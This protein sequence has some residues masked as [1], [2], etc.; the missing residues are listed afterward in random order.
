MTTRPTPIR[1]VEADSLSLGA[2]SAVV[3]RTHRVVREQ[4]RVMREQRSRRRSLWAPVAICS[5]LLVIACYAIWSVMNLNDINADGVIDSS[6]QMFIVMV[7]LLP[8]SAAIF[9]LVWMRRSRAAG[10]GEVS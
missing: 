10:V 4:A 1:P 2:R 6:D 8:V 7:W 5:T 3:N 9:A